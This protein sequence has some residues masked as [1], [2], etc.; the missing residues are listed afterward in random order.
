[1]CTKINYLKG[2]E[3]LQSINLLNMNQD[4]NIKLAK[5]MDKLIKME[6]EKNGKIYETIF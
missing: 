1:M 2:E 5:P 3:Q 4:G 6:E